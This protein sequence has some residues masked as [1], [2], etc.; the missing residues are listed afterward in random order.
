VQCIVIATP[1]KADE[2]EVEANKLAA[3][4]CHRQQMTNGIMRRKAFGMRF[5]VFDAHQTH[6]CGK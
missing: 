1:P 5:I 2:S 3:V 6:R 4:P